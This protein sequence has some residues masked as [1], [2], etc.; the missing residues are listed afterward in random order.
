MK[1]EN[2]AHCCDGYEDER[3]RQNRRHC[4]MLNDAEPVN[5]QCV[6]RSVVDDV[7]GSDIVESERRKRRWAMRD[8]NIDDS[9]TLR[10]RGRAPAHVG[11]LGRET[12][13]DRHS[14]K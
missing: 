13:L 10:A 6:H 7:G 14:G 1:G 4:Y 3:A 9:E 11:A 2:Q 12:Y 8:C 5:T